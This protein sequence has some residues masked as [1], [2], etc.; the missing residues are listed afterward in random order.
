[1]EKG[2]PRGTKDGGLAA[3][4]LSYLEGGK[5]ICLLPYHSLTFPLP[6]LSLDKTENNA[7]P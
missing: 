3:T 6:N 1:M 5:V 4:R 7:N 2:K